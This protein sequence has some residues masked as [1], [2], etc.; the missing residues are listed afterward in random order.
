M[1]GRKLEDRTGPITAAI[2]MLVR[3]GRACSGSKLE[4]C[5]HNGVVQHPRQDP[6]VHAGTMYCMY[7]GVINSSGFYFKYCGMK[8]RGG[9]IGW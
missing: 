3:P 4:T 2:S 8:T 6:V 7:S 1:V 5:N 9:G